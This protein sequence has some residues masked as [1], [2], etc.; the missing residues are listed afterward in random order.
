MIVQCTTKD[1]DKL[2]WI[3]AATFRETFADDNAATDMEDYLATAF[4][5]DKLKQELQNKFSEFYFAYNE[6][7][8][9]G[10]LKTNLEMPNSAESLEASLEIERIY[11]LQKFQ[12]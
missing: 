9:V 6:E 11:V 4:H 3:S 5:I 12:K 8:L 7:E 2:Q 1:L 10:Y